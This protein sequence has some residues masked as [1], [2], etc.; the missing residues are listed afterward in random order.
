[1]ALQL[2]A[3]AYTDE[4]TN[5]TQQQMIDAINLGLLSTGH[6]DWT[7]TWGPALDADRS[8]MMYVAGNSTCGQFAVSVRGTDWSFWLDWV[9]D[10]DNFLPLTEYSMFGVP[11][12]A[13]V[14]LAQGTWTGLAILLALRDGN[15]DLRQA[16][17]A[18]GREP[19]PSA[20]VIHSQSVKTTESGGPRGYDAAKK[21]QKPAP[22]KAGGRKRHIVTDTTGLLVGA[23]VH[24][25]DVQDRDG[26]VIVIEA[27]HATFP[28]LRHLFADA[29]YA[30]TKL[31]DAL[32]NLGRWTV[33]IV[34]RP[35]QATGFELL[36]RRWGGRTNICV[37]QPQ[38][39]PR[40]GL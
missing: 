31:H 12:G 19:S 18:A 22:A 11:V 28:W 17:E 24:S 29:A 3:L 16:R 7:V 33:E 15:A 2:S 9:E 32:A 40:Q 8:N 21:A 20:G 23:E 30:D 25:A 37:A 1:L 13:N 27:I 39:A 26:A 14:K 4:R 10:F 34:K 6:A 36:P 38:P 35:S 5:A